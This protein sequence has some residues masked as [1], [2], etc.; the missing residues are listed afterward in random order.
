MAKFL[1]SA[2]ST[3]VSTPDATL[4]APTTGR[5]SNVK[6]DITVYDK[7]VAHPTDRR[8]SGCGKWNG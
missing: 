1:A 2:P 3:A 7:A 8:I 4:N 5:T 6:V